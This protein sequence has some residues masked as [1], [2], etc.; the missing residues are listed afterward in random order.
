MDGALL[1]SPCPMVVT[2]HG[3]SALTRRSERLRMTLRPQLRHLA[4]QRAALVI[5]STEA[6]AEEARERFGLERDCIAVI[7]E[8][9]HPEMRP[10]DAD[11]IAAVRRR[12]GL[13]ERYLVWVGS[14]EHPDPSQHVAKLAAAPRELPLVLVGPTRPWAHELPGVKLT[15]HVGEGDLA[16]ILAG[17]Q[18]LVLPSDNEGLGLPAMEALACGTP[19]V[20]FD[21]PGMRELLGDR[22]VFV[23]PGDLPGLITAAQ[24]AAPPPALLAAW[25]W[26]DAAHATWRVYAQAAR[27][28]APRRRA[29]RAPAQ[30]SPSYR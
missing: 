10:R 28:A 21:V 19:V 6:I 12:H 13:P 17:A 8:A 16:A 1:H 24:L 26:H 22:V 4:V 23:A 5:V 7:P 27:M 29:G 14:L 20:A 15:G 18:A 3:L 2:L 25:T 11:E 9:P 30:A